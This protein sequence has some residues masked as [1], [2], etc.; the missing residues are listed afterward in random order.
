MHVAVVVGTVLLGSWVLNAP[1]DE[2]ELQVPEAA[3]AAAKPATS[4]NPGGARPMRMN[5][6]EGRTTRGAAGQRD[7]SAS[8]GGSQRTMQQGMS[9]IVPYAPTEAVPPGGA[10][11]QPMAPTSNA[12]QGL[13]STPGAGAFAPQQPMAP[14]APRSAP[15]GMSR[16]T[17]ETGRN[18]PMLNTNPGAVSAPVAEKPFAGYRPTSGVSPYMNLFRIQ[19]DSL[20]NYTSL[21]RPQVEQRFLNQ[22]FGRDIRS[23]EN[24]TRSQGLDLRQLYRSNQTLQGVGTPQ[25]YMNTQNYYPGSGQ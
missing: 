3:P 7:R 14:T 17:L 23:L 9:P 8:A 16:S 22:Q 19:G 11:G 20:D 6:G 5:R 13:I 12:P 1:E 18:L 21:V 24:N 25:Y 2:E 4:I 10:P 15:M